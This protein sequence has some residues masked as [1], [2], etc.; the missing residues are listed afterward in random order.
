LTGN[1]SVTRVLMYLDIFCCSVFRNPLLDLQLQDTCQL[2]WEGKGL[3]GTSPRLI[4]PRK[5]PIICSRRGIV[6]R[7]FRS[8][9]L[10]LL[11]LQKKIINIF[12]VF[13]CTQYYVMLT[14]GRE[15]FS[16]SASI[17]YMML[18]EDVNIFIVCLQLCNIQC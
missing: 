13:I 1:T 15:F 6:R 10:Q 4:A 11:T 14:I 18:K 9:P 8:A 16:Y 3:R 17:Y 12:S 5:L 7:L 2:C